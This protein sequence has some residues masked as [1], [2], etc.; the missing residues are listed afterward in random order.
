MRKLK[1]YLLMP[2]LIFYVSILSA[3]CESNIVFDSLVHNEILIDTLSWKCFENNIFSEW[4]SANYNSYQV[5]SANLKNI[6]TREISIKMVIYLATWCPDTRRELPRMKKIIDNLNLN[7]EVVLIGLNRK[8]SMSNE[9]RPGNKITHV[10][11]FVLYANGIEIGRIVEQ[12]K[13]RLEIDLN[14]FLK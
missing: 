14:N 6:H 2:L 12:P 11:T 13:T 7:W 10:P 3:Q 1:F 8:K 9:K 5:E 4:F